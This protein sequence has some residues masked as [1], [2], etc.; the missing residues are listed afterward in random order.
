M[1]TSFVNYSIP[2]RNH[3][4]ITIELAFLLPIM[5]AVLAFIFHVGIYLSW[6]SRVDHAA[7]HFIKIITLEKSEKRS[8]K[9]TNLKGVLNELSLSLSK[10]VGIYYSLLSDNPAH[11]LP[12]IKAG[13]NCRHNP[14]KDID[15]IGLGTTKTRNIAV[16]SICMTIQDKLPFSAFFIV[17]SISTIHSV[18]YYPVPNMVFE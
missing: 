12:P 5:A 7:Q 17:P 4:N 18:S 2:S 6:Q 15:E 11:R 9:N 3:G 1:K 14:V 10:N 13:Q 8:F 16:L